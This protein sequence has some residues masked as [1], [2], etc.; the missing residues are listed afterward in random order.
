[1]D[2]PFAVGDVLRLREYDPGTAEYTGRDLDVDVTHLTQP[3]WWGLPD[4]VC[5]MSTRIRNR[6]VPGEPIETS[7]TR[8]QLAEAVDE[9]HAAL[10]EANGSGLGSATS[11]AL[12]AI[13]RAHEALHKVGAGLPRVGCATPD[14]EA[15][16]IMQDLITLRDRAIPCGHTI[17]DL[18]LCG[19]EAAGEVGMPPVTKCGACLAARRAAKEAAR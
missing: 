7:Y 1:M 12:A 19:G 10:H 8:A 5:V 15:Q 11:D 2:R 18:I 17:A 6:E 14:P 4:N 13:A 3:G 9:A 16:R